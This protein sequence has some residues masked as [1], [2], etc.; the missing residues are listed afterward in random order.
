M[1]I[2]G[3]DFAKN[4]G[5]GGE[6]I[7]G[8][9]FEDES[10]DLCHSAPGLLSM[11]NNGANSNGSQFFIMTK[12]NP[13]LDRK[14]VVFGRVL[15]GMEVVHRVEESCGLSD[16]GAKGCLPSAHKGVTAF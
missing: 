2:Q 4:D 16:A 8:P 7:Y 13:S 5:T 12:A 9:T 3:G 15:Q 6:S 1:G 11:A 14:H 10:F